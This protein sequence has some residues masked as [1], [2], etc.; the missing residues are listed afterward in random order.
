M[1]IDR[2]DISPYMLEIAKKYI[3]NDQYKARLDVIQF[4]ESDIISYLTE[5]SDN[6]LDLAIMKYTIDH[7][8]DIDSLFGLLAKKLTP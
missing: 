3:D 5:A 7:I 1:I 4:I 2:V 6:S 8:A